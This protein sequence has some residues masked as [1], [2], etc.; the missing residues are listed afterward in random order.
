MGSFSWVVLAVDILSIAKIRQEHGIH[1]TMTILNR[2]WCGVRKDQ[3]T[4]SMIATMAR[5]RAIF[6]RVVSV[7]GFIGIE[8]V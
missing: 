7:W 6:Q 3:T 5:A 8:L 2:V 4:H 1:P